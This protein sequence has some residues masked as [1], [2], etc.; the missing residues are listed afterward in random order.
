MSNESS[1]EKRYANFRETVIA[2]IPCAAV[3]RVHVFLLASEHTDR[4]AAADDLAVGGHVRL[5]AE[6]G[7]STA[8]SAAETGDDLVE[9]QRGAGFLRDRADLMH[10]LTRLESGSAAL[11]RLDHDC[12]EFVSMGAENFQRSR[13][14]I[15]EHEHVFDQ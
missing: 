9:N 8:G 4:H 1:C 14:R 6:V 10:E 5:D 2:I 11:H 7:L 12:G 3:E 15:V 13:I